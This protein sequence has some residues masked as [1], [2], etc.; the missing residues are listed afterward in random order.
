MKFRF[1]F[2]VDIQFRYI[3]ILG[4]TCASQSLWQTYMLQGMWPLS[5]QI[6]NEYMRWSSRG[7]EVRNHHLW[8]S[9][10]IKFTVNL[11][12]K[13]ASDHS[14]WKKNS[15]S[16]HVL[17]GLGGFCVKRRQLRIKSAN[18]EIHNNLIWFYI[19]SSFV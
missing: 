18:I 9:Q 3:V 7:R 11:S 8:K 5:G 17:M 16:A 10:L 19:K 4:A 1:A 14:H 2:L 6:V 13:K 15:G 12:K